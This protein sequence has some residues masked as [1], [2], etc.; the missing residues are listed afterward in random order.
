MHVELEDH[1][2]KD[3][4]VVNAARVSFAKRKTVFDEAD[5]K[6]IAYLAKHN[7]WSPFAHTCLSF[8][9][10]SPIFVARQLAKHQVGAAWNE[11]SRRYIDSEPTVYYPDAWRERADNVKQGSGGTL[12]A[13]DS[14][15]IDLVYQTAM[16]DALR[17]YQTLLKRGVAPEQARMVL[18][19]STM[20]G[21]MWTGS[22]LFFSRVCQLRLDDHSQKETRDVAVQIAKHCRKKFP[23]SW[24][25]LMKENDH[26]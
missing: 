1:M 24:D 23:V 9:V 13:G 7:H 10:S 20:T 21:W 19:Q 8:R 11:E 3:L 25:A 17:A 12:T 15:L 14:W 5:A 18:P 16:N 4:S 22:V 26:D 6:L 2:G